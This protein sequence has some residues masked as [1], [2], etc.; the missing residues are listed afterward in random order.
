MIVSFRDQ[1]LEQL[2]IGNQIGKPVFSDSVVKKFRQNVQILAQVSSMRELSRFHGL[3]LEA[4]K[5]SHKGKYSIRVDKKYRLI[6]K[7]EPD[8]ILIA[9]ELIIDELSNHYE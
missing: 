2:F 3:N 5:G 1:Y 9:E 7:I 8:D 4:L 6:F